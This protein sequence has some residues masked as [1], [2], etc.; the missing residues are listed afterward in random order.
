MRRAGLVLIRGYQRL[1]SPFLG[2]N[3]RYQPTCSQYTY[4]AVERFGLARGIVMGGRRIARCHPFHEGGL[5]P[6]P[7]REQ[8]L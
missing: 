8:A 3:C 1:M 7:D 2:K 5:D 6:V 4:L